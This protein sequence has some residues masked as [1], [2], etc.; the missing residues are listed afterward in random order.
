MGGGGGGL[1]KLQPSGVVTLLSEGSCPSL[2]LE[3]ESYLYLL[4]AACGV[5][6][7]HDMTDY[8]RNVTFRSSLLGGIYDAGRC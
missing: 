3:V 6:C 4:S 1:D 5:R 8:D 7:M 2:T